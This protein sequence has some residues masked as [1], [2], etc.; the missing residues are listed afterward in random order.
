ML[1]RCLPFSL[2]TAWASS[3]VFPPLSFRRQGFSMQS[4]RPLGIFFQKMEWR[5][6][7]LP[8]QCVRKL[9]LRIQLS[10][11]FRE[12][13]VFS[14]LPHE[15]DN[16]NSSQSSQRQ[17]RKRISHQLHVKVSV[18]LPNVNFRFAYRTNNAIC[19]LCFHVAFFLSF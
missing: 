14:W 8:P 11:S 6:S 19:G 18:E 12:F 3:A 5:M 7:L 1:H 17:N 13:G 4:E 16:H 9:R 10:V 15:Y 2:R